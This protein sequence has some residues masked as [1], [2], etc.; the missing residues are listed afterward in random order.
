[1]GG[2]EKFFTN[3][4]MEKEWT[5]YGK[6]TMNF[7]ALPAKLNSL[8]LHQMYPFIA[9]ACALQDLFIKNIKGGKEEKYA[10]VGDT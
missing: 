9:V 7:N 10:I 5:K 6:S 4:A 1:M 8:L 3:L 2:K